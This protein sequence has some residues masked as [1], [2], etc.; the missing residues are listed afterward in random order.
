VD[1][2]QRFK[3][4]AKCG[5]RRLPNPEEEEGQ[6]MSTRQAASIGRGES[7]EP[8]GSCVALLKARSRPF[9]CDRAPPSLHLALQF[10]SE[11][12]CRSVLP[13]APV[14]GVRPLKNQ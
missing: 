4:P 6:H 7:A 1:E 3:G 9:E 11:A 5:L 12:S 13:Q 2:T 14:P 10:C 8:E